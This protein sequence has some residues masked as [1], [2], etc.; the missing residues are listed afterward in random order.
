MRSILTITKRELGGYF[1]S[2]LA[3]VFIVIFLALCGGMTFYIGG[4]LDRGRA[5]L[6]GFFSWHP[7]LYLFLVPAI[8]MRLWAEERRTGTIEFLT[9]LPITTAEAVVG[10]FLA[11]WLFIGIALSLTFPMWITVNYLGNP[12]NGIIVGGYLG[13]W[14]LAGGMLAIST[15]ISA[16]TKNQVIAFVLAAAVC[17]LFLM[18]GV[19]IV[20]ALFKGWASDAVVDTVANLSL[21]TSFNAIT[22][23]VI[24]LRHLFLFGSL[25]AISLFINVAVVDLKKGA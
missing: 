15:A 13:S 9:T 18:S 8:G 20:Q 7:W 5:D 22:E 4:W 11:A 10:K 25:I 21:L 19:E 16:L 17:F 24:D 1:G 6:S 14:V 2:P 3:Y 23:G 12:D